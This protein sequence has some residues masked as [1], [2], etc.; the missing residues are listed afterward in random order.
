M[1]RASPPERLSHRNSA[2]VTEARL[3]GIHREGLQCPVVPERLSHRNPTLVTE[4]R[5]TGVHREGLQCRVVLKRLR[6]RNPAR[7]STYDLLEIWP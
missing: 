6:Y 4:A 5:T 3:R 1:P 7:D 2:H